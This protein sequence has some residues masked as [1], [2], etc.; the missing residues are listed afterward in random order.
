[1]KDFGRRQPRFADTG[2]LG[3][4][5][6]AA[7]LAATSQNMEPLLLNRIAKLL[8]ADIVARYRIVLVP[9]SQDTLQPCADL[10]KV[11]MA[12]SQQLSLDVC[13][14]GLEFLP[15][16]LA[17]DREVA[18]PGLPADVRESQKVECFGRAFSTS[19]PTFLCVP[20]KLDQ[21]SLLRVRSKPNL[22]NRSRRAVR[23]RRASD[24]SRNP[25]TKSS[26]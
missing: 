25:M 23:Q 6:T 19:R 15:G 8:Q 7:T 10:F 14:L 26:A 20:P 3:P 17:V 2:E 11:E 4:S 21:A 16:R 12:E 13:Q 5:E 9:A 18:S 24:S 1:M 22:V